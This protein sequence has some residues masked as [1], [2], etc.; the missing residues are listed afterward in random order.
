MKKIICISLICCI[1][2]T[3]VGCK[4]CIST[5][6]RTVQVQIVDQ[7]YTPSYTT[8]YPNPAT[9]A[10]SVIGHPAAYR[11]TV[12]YDEVKYEF[13]EEDIYDKYHDK[14][15]EYING[16]LVIKKYDNGTIKYVITEIGD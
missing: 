3:L 8:V 10:M 16:K 13:T 5:E 14:V 7:H 1:L 12:E 9:H 6:T 4:K 11:I 15:E 2:L